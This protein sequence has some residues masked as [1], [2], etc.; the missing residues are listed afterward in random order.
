MSRRRRIGLIVGLALLLP[1]LALGVGL[2]LLVA[3]E[4][5]ARWTLGQLDRFGV[6]VDRVEGRL[7]GPLDLHGVAF[8]SPTLEVGVERAE[9]RWAPRALLARQV[10]VEALHL[11]GLRVVLA[12]VPPPPDEPAPDPVELPEIDL[13]VAVDLAYLRIDGTRLE[14]LGAEPLELELAELTG[15]LAF[16]EGELH[17][18]ELALRDPLADLELAGTILL[19]GDYPLDLS[20]GWRADIP[21]DAEL[22]PLAGSGALTGSVADLSSSLTLT[23][24]AEVV[25]EGGA[26]GLPGVPTWWVTAS[27]QRAAL[28]PFLDEPPLEW[29]SL[30]ADARG[31]GGEL[32]LNL[33]F[34]GGHHDGGD[35]DGEQDTAGRAPVGPQAQD[36]PLSAISGTLALE[37]SEGVFALEALALRAEFPDGQVAVEGRGRLGAQDGGSAQVELD[38]SLAFGELPTL[39][40]RS[41]IDATQARIRTETLM[42]APFPARL[43]AGVDDPTEE[44]RWSAE[45]EIPDAFL[46]AID[47]EWPELRLAAALSARGDLTRIQSSGR[48]D[49]D[50][51][52]ERFALALQAGGDLEASRFTVDELTLRPE[53]GGLLSARAD[54]DLAGDEPRFDASGEW[55]EI[56]RALAPEA[57]VLRSEAGSF[58]VSGTARAWAAQL[59]ASVQLDDTP[60]VEVRLEGRGSDEDF[61]LD[62]LTLSGEGVMG[63]IRGRVAWSPLLA[64]DLVA[65]GVEVDLAPFQAPVGGRVSLALLTAGAL[66]E[67]GPQA[68]LEIPGAAWEEDERRVELQGAG[69]LSGDTVRVEALDVRSGPNRLHLAGVLDDQRALTWRVEAPD[70]SEGAG[71]EGRVMGEGSVSG[72]LR[73]PMVQAALEAEGVALVGGQGGAPLDVQGGAP[74][75]AQDGPRLDRARLDA[76]VDLTDSSPSHVRVEFVATPA[77]GAPQVE[78]SL[79]GE[80]FLAGHR[81]KAAAALDS[82]EYL[83]LVL[84]GALELPVPEAGTQ[85]IGE[86]TGETASPAARPDAPTAAQPGQTGDPDDPHGGS[87]PRWHGELLVLQAGLGAAGEWALEAPA[88]LRLSPQ[89]LVLSLLCLGSEGAEACVEGVWSPEDGGEG[90]A[91]LRGLE[92]ERFAELLPPGLVVQGVAGGRGEFAVDPEGR[93][94]VRARGGIEGGRIRHPTGFGTEEERI[95][96]EAELRLLVLPEGRL[97]GEVALRLDDGSFLLANLAT[98]PDPAGPNTLLSGDVAVELQDRGLLAATSEELWN[99]SGVVRGALTLGGTAEVPLLSGELALEDGRVEVP[100]FGLRLEGLE[101]RASDDGPDAWRF[102][103]EVRSGPGS[104]ALEGSAFLPRPYRPGSVRAQVSGRDFQALDSGLGRVRITPSLRL[105]ADAEGIDVEGTVRVPWAQLTPGDVE[106]MVARSPDVVVVGLE[107]EVPARA[108]APPGLAA[109]IRVEMG[110]SVSFD[111]FGVEGRITGAV[112]LVEEPGRLTRG[113]GEFRLVDGTFTAAR[114]RLTIERG[115]LIFSDRPIEDPGLDLRITRQTRDILAIM[116]VRGTA[117]EPEVT[118]FSDPVLSQADAMAYLL[119]GRPVRGTGERDGDLMEEVAT[120]MGL[121]G[122]AAV[123]DRIGPSLGLAEARIER[124]ETLTDAALVVGTY[125]TPRLFVSYG[126]GL[127]EEAVS[128]LRIRYEITDRWSFRTESGRETGADLLFSRER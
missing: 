95:L 48:L 90:R 9:L 29:V 44:L 33:A 89:A 24:P 60:E 21:G 96:D 80:G 94:T 93:A 86:T 100:E 66:E 73:R 69:G 67:E 46:P 36:P 12:E 65:E 2:T 16:R 118:V 109:R 112:T 68:T 119:I 62:D 91:D 55:S 58:S 23:S 110:D 77:P 87:L 104:I 19:R 128:T 102:T 50:L 11:E 76:T 28:A 56:A 27:A 108:A 1:L 127:F 72:P 111:G 115:R 74:L 124:G 43:V 59:G 8:R 125:V 25:V 30:E 45:L 5:G 78:G 97:E 37:G 6:E 92:L 57:Q 79:T 106:G 63:A 26:A 20:L 105:Q 41:G 99:S 126:L 13:P 17:V 98:D 85:V 52:G 34:Q 35:P 3:T 113:Q 47:P 70:L 32:A 116:E 101:L 114:Q 40:G 51:A 14:R 64:W 10:S 7:L 4:G 49:A 31:V 123:L 61:L 18:R 84:S 117:L 122:G 83:D 38:W 54:V 82:G 75:D 15:S 39:V 107:E 88:S 120:S 53:A 121:A 81:L 22:P 103:G 42:D 71:L